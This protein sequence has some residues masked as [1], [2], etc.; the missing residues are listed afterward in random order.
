MGLLQLE[1]G[2]KTPQGILHTGPD[3]LAHSLGSGGGIASDCDGA[4][5]SQSQVEAS[6]DVGPIASD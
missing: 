6:A 3:V 1:P 4:R 2:F 5:V